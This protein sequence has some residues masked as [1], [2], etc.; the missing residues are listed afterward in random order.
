MMPIFLIVE[1]LEALK[2]LFETQ[3]CFFPRVPPQGAAAGC[4]C[5][6]LL[7]SAA[8]RVVC[9]VWSWPVGAAAAAA[10]CRCRVLLQGA[11]A[12][13]VCALWRWPA[14]A[15]A[16]F[17]CRVLLLEWRVRAAACALELACWCLQ[18]A[19]TVVL[20]CWCCCRV[21][22][23][24]CCVLW[25][26]RAGAAASGVCAVELACRC[27]HCRV[28]LSCAAAECFVRVLLSDCCVRFGA[29]LL[30]PLQGAVPLQCTAAACGCRVLLLKGLSASWELGWCYRVLL[31]GCCVRYE[32]W[33]LVSLQGVAARCHPERRWNQQ[34]VWSFPDLFSCPFLL[35]NT[36]NIKTYRKSKIED[37][38]RHTKK[39]RPPITDWQ[40]ANS[41]KHFVAGPAPSCC[42]GSPCK[43]S[44]K[45]SKGSKTTRQDDRSVHSA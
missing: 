22:L 10:G 1:R 26:W 2:D 43:K 40:S 39:E 8:V 23:S 21:L 24:K 33:V 35:S 4:R 18:A 41:A 36:A 15:A 44:N 12:R 5:R 11:A 42:V 29:G 31:S 25:S 9:A 32:A 38:Q 19:V 45:G 30:V 20:A 3:A 13:A 16:R 27:R 14:G 34:A 6:V 28:S 17:R 7:E 37:V